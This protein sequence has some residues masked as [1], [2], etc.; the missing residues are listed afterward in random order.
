MLTSERMF[1]VDG[2]MLNTMVWGQAGSGKSY[3]I[4]AMA[5]DFF[6]RNQDP[7]YRMLYISPK[8]EGFQD[9]MAKKQK[10]VVDTDGMMDSLAKNR[11]TVYYPPMADLDLNVDDAIETVFAMRDVNPDMKVTI[12]IDD[13][14]IFLSS[15]KAASDAHKRLALTGRSRGIRAVYVAH[16]IVFARELEGQ[17]D[18][19]VGFSNPSPIYYRQAIERFDFD[20]APYQEQIGQRKYSFV[21]KD[22]TAQTT[23]MMA[24]IGE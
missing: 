18:L 14:Q 21:V 15:R 16:N 11:L 22:I 20:P 6:R 2:S 13:A 9:L 8:G 17:I 1:G 7:N 3:A 19:L 24:P 4:E 12:V 23:V 10:V 5:K